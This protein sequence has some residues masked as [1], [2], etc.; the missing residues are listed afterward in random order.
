MAAIVEIDEQN[1]KVASSIHTHNIANSNMGSADA[2]SLDPAKNPIAQGANSYEKWQLIHVVSMGTATSISNLKVW[3]TGSLG[4]HAN[5][6]TNA[7]TTSYGGAVNFTT[8]TNAVSTVATQSMPTSAPTSAN[9]G[10]GGSLTG[11]LTSPGYSD[12]LVH[13]IQTD[14]SAI[15]GS[16]TTLNYSYDETS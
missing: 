3:R 14:T 11:S 4:A 8:P 1:G 5:H 15:S 10:I 2:S 16:S 9:L 6:L 12:F 13:Q 7:R